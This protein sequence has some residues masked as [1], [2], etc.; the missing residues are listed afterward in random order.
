MAMMGADGTPYNTQGEARPT[1][2]ELLSGVHGQMIAQNLE[3]QG[4][5]AQLRSD[6]Q[7]A[8]VASKAGADEISRL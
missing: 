4:L 1:L 3:T 5:I 6:V 7:Q 2:Q 8:I